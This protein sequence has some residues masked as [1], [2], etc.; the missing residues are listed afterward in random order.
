MRVIVLML[1]QGHSVWQGQNR[2][3]VYL[4]EA[5]CD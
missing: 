4:F 3:V 1:G 2:R 5:A